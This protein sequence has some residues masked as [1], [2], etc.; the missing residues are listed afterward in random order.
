[1]GFPILL[2][3]PS[4]AQARPKRQKDPGTRQ[5]SWHV[6]TVS[7]ARCPGSQEVLPLKAAAVL[8]DEVITLDRELG[9]QHNGT[10]SEPWWDAL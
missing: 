1:M 8:H 6:A 5:V 3:E 9:T 10:L 7:S 2:K 4:K